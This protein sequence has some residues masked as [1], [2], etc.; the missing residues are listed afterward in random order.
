MLKRA[1]DIFFSLTGLLLLSPF[2][3]LIALFIRL[4]SKGPIFFSQERIG[5]DFRPFRILKFRTMG[6]CNNGPLITTANDQRI[7]RIGKFLRKYKIDELPQ[8]FNVLKGDMSLVGPRPEVKKYV[9]LFESDYR[10]ILTVRPGITDPASIMYINEEDLLAAS[11][12]YE[13]FYIKKILPDKIRIS[14]K[15]IEHPSVIK[16]TLIIFKTLL[17]TRNYRNF[18]EYKDN[19]NLSGN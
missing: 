12:D 18:Y 2:F 14:L 13:E 19:K 17:K 8:L 5:R 16:D 3:I 15:Y 4:D 11:R 7:T 1:F 6:C 10:K 9:A